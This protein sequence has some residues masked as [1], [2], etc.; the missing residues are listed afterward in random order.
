M[1]QVPLACLS[2]TASR[3]MRMNMRQHGLDTTRL[4]VQYRGAI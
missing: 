3:Y 1:V 2:M 4:A